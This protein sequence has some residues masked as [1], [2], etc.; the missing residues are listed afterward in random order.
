MK[1]K[2]G[3]LPEVFR[4][5]MLVPALLA[6]TVLLLPAVAVAGPKNANS[7]Q[8]QGNRIPPKEMS[9][10]RAWTPQTQKFYCG[11]KIVAPGDSRSDV[12]AV[13][14][15]PAW[16]EMR[17]DG[18]TVTYLPDGTPVNFTTTEEWVYNFGS[19]R[20][21]YVLR[22]QG[23]RLAVIETG[24]YG[25]DDR[26]F[27]RNCGDGRNIFTGDSKL[28]VVVKCGPPAAGEGSAGNGTASKGGWVPESDEWVYNFGPDRFIYKVKFRHGKVYDISTGG[29][30]H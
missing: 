13:C 21:L 19:R 29:Y 12:L 3:P 7:G 9:G 25:Y 26:D 27:G 6:V 22:F 20:F 1:H 14:G 2:S 10:M 11:E 17:D 30:G 24:G 18:V 16:R 23:D 15:E 4:F 28:E 8:V 5:I